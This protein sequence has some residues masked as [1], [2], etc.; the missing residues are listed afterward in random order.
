MQDMMNTKLRDMNTKQIVLL[1]FGL[2]VGYIV[3]LKLLKK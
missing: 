3:L 1:A 2:C